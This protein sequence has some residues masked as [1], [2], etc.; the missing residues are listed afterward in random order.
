MELQTSSQVSKTFGVS[1]RM[2]RYYEQAGLIKGIRNENYPYRVYNEE[3][4]KRLQQIIILRKLQIPIKQISVILSNPDAATVIEIFKTNIV[5]LQ[6][7]INALETIKSALEIFVDKIEELAAVRLNLN[8]LTDDSVIRLAE[9]L[10]LIQ[11]NV[12]ENKTMDELNKAA[13]TLEKTKEKN[14]RVVYTPTETVAFLSFEPHPN[15]P[16]ENLNNIMDILEKFIKDADLF[17][18]K[19]DFK[20]F[21]SDGGKNL[22]CNYY[23]TIPDDLEVS[24]PFKKTKFAGGLWAVYTIT[25]DNIEDRDITMRWVRNSNEYK[26]NPEYR[27]A[28]V[29][30]FNPLNIYGLKNTTQFDSAFNRE[31]FDEYE[32]IQEIEQL[33]DEQMKTLDLALKETEKLVSQNKTVKIDLTTMVKNIESWAK[34]KL[35]VKY[36]N[37][38][39]VITADD[40]GNGMATTQNFKLPL[41]IKVRAKTNKEINIKYAKGAIV[42]RDSRIDDSSLPIWDIISGNWEVHKNGAGI[43]H[44]EF[45]DFEWI[46]G[47]DIMVAK[48]N[49]EIRHIGNNYTYMDEL[50]KSDFNLLS[51]VIIEAVT[52]S[53]VTVESLR[54]TEIGE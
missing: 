45:V 27:P 18:T 53:T 2:L 5:E 17:Q 54:V 11:K 10:S 39:M 37:G 9:S 28:H 33:T 52:G 31:Y 49:G 51:P 38:L 19:P 42:F 1:T 48:A 3:N 20:V 21:S 35:D 4:I 47:K 30:F 16:D 14:I 15:P 43:P 22:G 24:E 13:E 34:G 8:L 32:P 40:W 44:D 41:R 12:K 26:W 36:E 23:I 29:V 25:P 7:E 6:T 46:F 50:N